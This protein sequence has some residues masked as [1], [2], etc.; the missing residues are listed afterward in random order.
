MTVLLDPRETSRITRRFWEAFHGG[1]IQYQTCAACRQV[2]FPPRLVCSSCGGAEFS[3]QVSRGEGVVIALT[4]VHRPASPLLRDEVPF[5]LALIDLDEG[6]RMMGRIVVEGARAI[7]I[8]DRV[9]LR[10]VPSRDGGESSVFCP[11]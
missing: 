7:D 4:E 5:L 6:F 9:V 2:T 8:D 1:E 3:W 10:R 11:V